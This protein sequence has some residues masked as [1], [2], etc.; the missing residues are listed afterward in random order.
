MRTNKGAEAT[1]TGRALA[2]LSRQLLSGLDDITVQMHEWSGGTRAQVRI[3]ANISA[4]TQFLPKDVAA[5][6]ARYP[7]VDMHLH[8]RISSVIVKPVVENEANVGSASSMRRKTR[9]RS[10]RTAKPSW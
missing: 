2:N 7:Q 4:I 9:S 3:F 10:F 5:F 8:E 1:P 6:L